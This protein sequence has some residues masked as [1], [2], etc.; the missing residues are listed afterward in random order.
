YRIGCS[1]PWARRSRANRRSGRAF[2]APLHSRTIWTASPYPRAVAYLATI[3]RLC[4]LRNEEGHRNSP[5]NRNIERY[6]AEHHSW[7]ARA[8]MYDPVFA[9]IGRRG[10]RDNRRVRKTG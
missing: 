5:V 2:R 9:A 3:G 10:I 4:K 7:D 1:A 8:A 6:M